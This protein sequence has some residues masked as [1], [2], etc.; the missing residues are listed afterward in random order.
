M[1]TPQH[2]QKGQPWIKGKV[3]IMGWIYWHCRQP[4]GAY[5]NFSPITGIQS[6]EIVT[7]VPEVAIGDCI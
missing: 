6:F 3:V 1:K 5:S 4:S 2:F 7:V